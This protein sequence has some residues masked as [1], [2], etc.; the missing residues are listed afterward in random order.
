[1]VPKLS[2]K[3]CFV[4]WVH[5]LRLT[6][7]GIS[8]VGIL[9]AVLYGSAIYSVFVLVAAVLIGIPS[10]LFGIIAKRSQSRGLRRLAIML[11]VPALTLVFVSW[12][13]RQIPVRAAPLVQAIDNFR[14]DTGHYPESLEALIP[15]HLSELPDVRFSVF[16]PAITYR[17]HAGKPY[18]AIPSAIG[19]MFA[20]FE[21]DFEANV[22]VHNS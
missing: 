17:I 1:M 18:L 14:R 5:E 6:W 3:E 11:L 9:P 21:Y 10:V 20:Q 13:D 8:V 22:W 19:D 15:G 4:R 7:V 12:G 2:A 16:E